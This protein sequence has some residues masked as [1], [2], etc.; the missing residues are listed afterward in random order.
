MKTQEK[1]TVELT[2]IEIEELI[3]SIETALALALAQNAY[4]IFPVLQKVLVKLKAA[5]K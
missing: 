1:K 5:L 3:S 4:A 2:N